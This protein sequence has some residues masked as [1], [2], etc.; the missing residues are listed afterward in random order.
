MTA[1]DLKQVARQRPRR[2]GADR[3]GADVWV[4]NF[5]GQSVMRINID[6]MKTTLYPAPR[7]GM[8]PY[9]AA[10]DTS[11]NAWVSFTNADEVG[12][13]DPTTEKWT[14]YSWPSR[15]TDL[16]H[17]GMVDH[18]GVVQVIGAYYTSARVGRM[19]MRTEQDVQ[20]LRARVQ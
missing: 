6:T 16:R 15:G 2:P 1:E 7:M 19:V 5:S 3:A 13:F 11:H 9:M 14:M 18:N 10:I 12:K 8:N 20:T 17:L 4:P